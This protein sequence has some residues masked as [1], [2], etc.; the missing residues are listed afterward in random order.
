MAT[1]V[2]GEFMVN[3]YIDEV[4]DAKFE[5][6]WSNYNPHRLSAHYVYNTI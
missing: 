6:F 4:D 3:R 2:W 1:R 5:I